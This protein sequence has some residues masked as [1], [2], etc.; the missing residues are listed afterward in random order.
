MLET[1]N[2]GEEMKMQKLGEV[3]M[4]L[5]VEIIG[6]KRRGGKGR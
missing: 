2:K 4:R 3:D 1:E 5:G 6:E